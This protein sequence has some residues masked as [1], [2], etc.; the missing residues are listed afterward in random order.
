MVKLHGKFG[1]M[2]AKLFNKIFNGRTVFVTGHTG[3]IGSWLTLWLK[4]LGANVVGFSL[5]PPTVPSLF[6]ILQLEKQINHIEG[7]VYNITHLSESIEKFKPEIIFH[8][9]AQSIV[10]QSYKNPLDTYKTNIMGTI[11]LLD[12]IRN[13]QNVKA[14]V[15]FT[16]DKCYDNKELI[17]YAYKETDPMGGFDPYSSSK[18]ASELIISSY[19]NSF[20]NDEKN[21]TKQ[22]G[23]ASIRA[24][25]VIGGGDWAENRIIPDCIRSIISKKK[26]H[27]RNPNAYRPW[28]YVLEPISGML[29]LSCKMLK[30]QKKFSEAWNFGPAESNTTVK[31]LVSKIIEKWHD[32]NYDEEKQENSLYESS[33]LKLNCEKAHKLLN[34]FPTY[35]LEETTTETI[36]W[37]KSFYDK[38]TDMMKFSVKQIENYVK[39]ATKKE[40]EWAKNF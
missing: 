4:S 39:K 8:L 22:V 36:S 16:S 37:Y 33:F 3:F 13:S 38:G 29:Y 34:W 19:R 11:N 10:L 7:D 32:G 25:N 9:A 30:N 23:I 40:I 28:Q 12:T 15:M 21:T 18:G 5:Q 20:F 6:E 26:I 1:N 31:D 24:G 2:S 27:L 17:D 35:S 14:C